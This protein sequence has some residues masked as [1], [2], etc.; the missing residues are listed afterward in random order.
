MRSRI[1][2]VS[3]TV[4]FLAGVSFA[5]LTPDE[6]VRTI[7]KSEHYAAYNPVNKSTEELIKA[8]AIN[9]ELRLGSLIVAS[10]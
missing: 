6:I 3:Y 1:L 9:A 7:I 2:A 8:D 4:A 5:D 10:D